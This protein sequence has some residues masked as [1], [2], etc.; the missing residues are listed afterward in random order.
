MKFKNKRSRKFNTPDTQLPLHE[1][2]GFAAMEQYKLLRT[3]LSF[4]LPE[5]TKCPVIGVTSATRGDGK[6]TTSINLAYALAAD[7]KRVLLID[8]DLRLPSVA[9][10]MGIHGTP[11]LTN[12]LVGYNESS[13][14]KYR[15]K[16]LENWYIIPSGALPP[17]P[18]E[19]L[20]SQKMQK[21]LEVLKEQFD[22]IVLDLPP[23]SVVSDG[24]AVAKLV[25]GMIL[26]V[27]QDYTDK[28]DLEICVSHL[29]LAGVK[30]MGCV[31]NDSKD[32]SIGRY[33]YNKYSSR[34]YTGSHK[35]KSA[36]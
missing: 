13:L 20:G 25:T 34:Y 31:L 17:N 11:G 26:V 24:L 14:E 12:L 19:L 4:V 5:D 33:R 18:S 35:K 6:S 1:N 8:C 21:F 15:S 29:T 27:R 3:N 22:Y 10:K 32:K 28:K 7:K 16:V 2:L 36:K 9:K 30:V 23:V